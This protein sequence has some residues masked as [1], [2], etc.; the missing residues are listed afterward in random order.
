MRTRLWLPNTTIVARRRAIKFASVG[1]Y[2]LQEGMSPLIPSD[3][4]TSHDVI[5][6]LFLLVT[7]GAG[8]ITF[9]ELVQPGIRWKKFMHHFSKMRVRIDVVSQT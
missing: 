1:K 6:I 7:T 4:Q 9:V 2:F 3:C 8:A 5:S